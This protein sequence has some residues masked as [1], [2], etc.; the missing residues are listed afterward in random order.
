VHLLLAAALVPLFVGTLVAAIALWPR[1]PSPLGTVEVLDTGARYLQVR[2]TDVPP[3]GLDDGM[4][5]VTG[6][7][8]DGSDV[9]VQVPPEHLEGQLQPG[10]SIKV[11]R[12]ASD[13]VSGTPY[14]FVDY[15]RSAPIG[16]LVAVYCAT[17]LLVA[18]WRGLAAVAGL[19]I[20]LAGIAFFTLPALLAGSNA[21]AVGLT[22][23]SALMFVVLYLAHGFNARTTTALLGTMAGLAVTGLLG[24][25][26]ADAAH[27]TGLTD[28]VAL[29][30]PAYAPAVDVSG[31]VLCGLILAG[32]GVLND[33]TITQA[34]AV[35][36]LHATRP[37]ASR[38]DLFAS[39]MRIGRDHIASTVY[40][41]AFAYVGAALPL[42]LM[43]SLLSVPLGHT[44]TTGEIAEEVVRTLVSSIGLVLAIPLTTAVAAVVVSADRRHVAADQAHDERGGPDR[45]DSGT[46]DQPPVDPDPDPHGGHGGAVVATTAALHSS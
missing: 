44:L 13:E 6:V 8:D 1:G 40:T 27:L 37:H 7:L 17:V 24:W 26:A 12:L 32:L 16:L 23:A 3:E 42:L 18:R 21:L 46:G 33:V 36:E 10:D 28:D 45:T 34:S 15:V 20:S 14:V 35:W 25:W 43:V 9:T 11:L 29:Q 2:V 19:A 4:P 41:I 38:R 5:G 39:G 30:L 22:T 31:V